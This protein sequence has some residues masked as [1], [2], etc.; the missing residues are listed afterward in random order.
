M[1]QT[2]N[3]APLTRLT[4]LAVPYHRMRRDWMRNT[5]EDCPA[6]LVVVVKGV[7]KEAEPLVPWGIHDHRVVTINYYDNPKH[8]EESSSR[9]RGIWLHAE[10]VIASRIRR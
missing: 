1:P 3:L 2:L 9:E 10:A 8:W 5:L 4:H 6:L 7:V